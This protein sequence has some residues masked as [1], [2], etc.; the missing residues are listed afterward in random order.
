MSSRK[1]PKCRKC[2]QAMKGHRA[3]S[4]LVSPSPSPS[5]M[6]TEGEDELSSDSSG[7]SYLSPPPSPPPPSSAQPS[8]SG[9][10]SSTGAPVR[11]YRTYTP[12]ILSEPSFIIPETGYFH[13]VNPNYRHLQQNN[14]IPQ[15]R[16][17]TPTEIIGSDGL[18]VAPSVRGTTRP[19][20]LLQGLGSLFNV[21]KTRPID[22]EET[23]ATPR[24]KYP[25]W[26]S[27]TAV[28]GGTWEA[29]QQQGVVLVGRPWIATM[30]NFLDSFN[31]QLVDLFH[32]MWGFAPHF[33]VTL[34]ASLIGGYICKT[35][36]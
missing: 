35:Y 6:K 13:R 25:Y 33:V 10:S 11:V 36:L 22:I 9:A 5:P 7:P 24:K 21:Q 31:D 27:G 30:A 23:A 34:V 1:A 20:E 26:N 4:C 28:I 2:G 18:P 12:G 19:K 3:M 16:S 29:D 14:P 15:T 32:T 17:L 8:T